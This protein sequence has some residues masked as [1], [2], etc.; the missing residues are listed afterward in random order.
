MKIICNKALLLNSINTVSK[1]VPSK[2]T[3]NMPIL[4]CILLRATPGGFKMTATD[5]E[6]GIESKLENISIIETGSIALEAKIF[7]EIVRR[8]PDD[9]VEISTDKDN[10]TLIKCINSEYTLVGQRGDEFPDL[11]TVEK[12]LEYTL[13][14]SKLK[15]MIRQTIFS[16]STDESKIAL[17]GELLE[18]IDNSMNLVS[19]DG[20]RLSFRKTTLLNEN[21]DIKAVIPGKTLNEINK[22]LSN[23]DEFEVSLY[24][25]DKH[26]LFDLGDSTVVSRII[27]SDFI[28]Y[29]QIFSND[30]N[31]IANINRKNII[32]CLER[33]SLLSRENKKTP[34][35]IEIKNNKLIITSNTELGTAYEEIEI[36]RQGDDIAIAF[37]PK[38]IIDALKA[39]DDDI[40]NIYF[41]SALSPCII[42][43]VNG[44]EYKYLVLPVR[45]NS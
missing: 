24:F 34:V 4:E 26:I 23:E 27:N 25:T 16:V 9:N 12:N 32:T 6:F 43:P 14:Q 31:T 45:L 42:K 35:K 33:A 21:E 1:A 39:I 8:L 15:D 37:N 5:L 41:T 10:L 36:N 7:S 13:Q 38:Y 2:T 3:T 30:Y 11:P 19:V 28:N 22:I 18:I 44:D 40:I 17:T 20:Y 29:E